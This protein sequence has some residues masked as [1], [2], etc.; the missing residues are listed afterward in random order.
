MTFL[1]LEYCFTGARVGA[2]LENKVAEVERPEGQMD[3]LVFEGLT[4]RVRP[5]GLP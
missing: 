3:K 1:I 2:Y 5:K 4:W